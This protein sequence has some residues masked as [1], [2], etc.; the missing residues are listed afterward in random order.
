MPGD[1][2]REEVAAGVEAA[3]SQAGMLPRDAVHQ[4]VDLFV[5]LR[6]DHELVAC[7]RQVSGGFH[8][9]RGLSGSGW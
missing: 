7:G 3:E 2:G 9:Q 4:V 6:D 8:H 5:G 1:T